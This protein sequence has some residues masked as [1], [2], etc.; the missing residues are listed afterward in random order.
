MLTLVALPAL[1]DFPW[2][3]YALFLAL[4]SIGGFILARVGPGYMPMQGPVALA[5]VWLFG[6]P[7]GM[8]IAATVP[9]LLVLARRMSVWVGL[10]AFGNAGTA[11]ALAGALYHRFSRPPQAQE[12]SWQQAVVLASAGALFVL[13]NVV[14]AFIGRYLDSGDPQHVRP[15]HIARLA[16]FTF[17]A[18]VPVSY[19]L[20]LASSVGASAQLL[21]L[22]IW[23]I[24]SFAL[25]GMAEAREANARLEEALAEVRHLAITDTL[26]GLGNR[27]HFTEVFEQALAACRDCGA[28]LALLLLDLRGLKAINDR[29]G[30]PRGDEVLCETARVLRSALG[31]GDQAFR[32]GGD[33]FAV[34]LPGTTRGTAVALGERLCAA[35]ETLG[36]ARAEAVA[37]GA[38]AGVAV[39][40][41]DGETVSQ[42]TS[43]A[44]AALYAARAAGAPVGTGLTATR[45]SALPPGAAT[46]PS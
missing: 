27:R 8:P 7:A 14:I 29:L 31:P 22:S 3:G 24:T 43:A 42:L 32:V 4:A 16:G 25:K 26:T 9:I 44:D 40:P 12:A 2:S 19:V 11:L 21:T 37:T 39:F 1:A 36:L 10:L 34:I 23:L 30:H 35:L 41:D 13:G 18:Y 33:E 6:W 28:P 45:A 17:L 20:A 38:T 15:R 5:A 46:A